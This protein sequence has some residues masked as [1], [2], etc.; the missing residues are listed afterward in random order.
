[1]L[2]DGS[3]HKTRVD[4]SAIVFDSSGDWSY[5]APDGHTA[6]GGLGSIAIAPLSVFDSHTLITSEIEGLLSK[7]MV[8]GNATETQV[9]DS[10]GHTLLN[11]DGSPNTNPETKIP[12]AARYVAEQGA[13][14]IDLIQGNGNFMQTIVGTGNGA[15]GAASLGTDAMAMISGVPSVKGQAD[16][17]GLDPSN[18]MLTFIPASNKKVTADLVINA[19]AGV[20]REAQLTSVATGGAAE[21]LQFMGS[22]R[23]HVVLQNKGGAGMFSLN[24]TSNADGQVQT[25][26]TGRMA[27]AAGDTVDL[28]PSNWADIQTATA[29]V[30]VHHT[31]GTTA[32][33]TM[34]NGGKGEVLNVKE[35]DSFTRNVARFAKLSPTGLSAIIDW[36]DGTTSAGKVGAAG[37]DVIVTGSHTYDKQGYFPTRITLSDSSGPLRQATGEAIVA[38]TKFSLASAKIAAFA[39]VPFTGKVATLTDLPSGDHASDFDVKINWG[40][41]TSSAGTLQTT[42]A[43]KFDVRGSHTW[44]T[45]G[46]KSVVITVTEHGSASGQGHTIKITSNKNFSGAVAQLQLPLP[47][48][49]PGD[50][51]ATIDWGDNK[52][53]TG[54]LTLQS[55]GTVILTGSHSYATGNKSFV[56]H[57]TVTGGPSAKVTSTAVVSPA[58]GTVTGTLFNDIDGDGKKDPG[59]GGLS[60]RTVFIDK[61]K[62][63]KLDPG[64]LKAVTNSSGVYTITNVPA[65]NI[66]VIENVPSGFRVDAPASGFY[67]MTLK[68]GQT[69]SKLNFADTQLALIS[70]TVFLDANGNKTRD[71]SETG[72]ANRTV[73]L[74]LN[75]DGVL[76]STEPTALTDTTGAFAFTTVNPGTYVV[77]LQPVFGYK[78]TTPA[79]GTYSV[80]VGKGSTRS[81]GLFGEKPVALKFASPASLATTGGKPVALV[82]ADF[83]ND[84]KLDVATADSAG[85]DVTVFLNKGD[86]S[87]GA[88]KKFAVGKNPVGIV[89]GDFN[90]DGKTDLAVADQNDN[91]VQI[92][93]GAGNG[94]FKLATTALSAAA[95]NGIAAFDFN[96]DKTT[97]IVVSNRNSKQITLFLSK[98][99]GGFAAGK[100]I[101]VEALPNAITVADVNG[102]KLPDLLVSNGDGNAK[103]DHGS[104]SVLLGNG[105]GGFSVNGSSPALTGPASIAVGDFDGDGSVDVLTANPGNT[106]G[107][108][109]F[110]DGKGGVGSPTKLS[111]GGTP[112]AVAAGD[113][114]GDGLPDAAYADAG[115]NTILVLP[116]KGDGSFTAPLILTAGAAPKRW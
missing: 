75:N 23:D 22:Q 50:Y 68:P 54:K 29:N 103:S 100:T 84:K 78:I 85:N 32:T 115:T 51:V 25:F 28:L 64:E 56:T 6:S 112:E 24:L 111:P 42:S 71:A 80:T 70:G 99:G 35:G 76:Q 88:G 21:T 18:D 69:L 16:K 27:L 38:D 92:L 39:G 5:N 2:Q 108:I 46:T 97:D 1:M 10:T 94:T 12:G 58:V 90:G 45:T 30:V 73:Y 55:D 86:G 31:N 34:A 67:D 77:R 82:V 83:N 91:A 33:I 98:S 57:F 110:G 36:G 93:V 14:P 113:F 52:K 59:E 101:G 11:A 3:R 79:G 62:N 19:P 102:D 96:G 40:D 20:Q 9:T 7:F 37:T 41:G 60:G 104:V 48:S 26:T 8:F 17:F 89:A 109:L 53:S 95:P 47:G 65:G 13:T 106:S 114:N 107:A 105:K 87:F 72:R 49:A 66:R 15:Y 4:G 63:F 44:A 81:G 43:G 116:G 74:D 61:N